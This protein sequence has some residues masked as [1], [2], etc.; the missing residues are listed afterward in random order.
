M[1]KVFI[2]AVVGLFLAPWVSRAATWGAGEEYLL[3]SQERI[4]ENLYQAAGNMVVR[5]EIT[6]DALLAGGN[7]LVDAP[8]G[9]DVFLAGGSINFLGDAG[10]DVRILGG[11]IT[12]DS[13]I[14]GDVLV[15]G[16]SVNILPSAVIAGDVFVA[17]G[18]VVLAGEING[19]VKI[20]AA[21]AIVSG[22]VAKN[23]D[24]KVGEK[25]TIG[26]KGIIK[27][28]LTYQ[29]P[30]GR[31]T[32]NGSVEGEIIADEFPLRHAAK[33][34]GWFAGIFSLVGLLILLVSGLLLILF[35]GRFSKEVAALGAENFG[36]ESF[37]GFAILIL[38]PALCL[39]L[40]ISILGAIFAVL[41]AALYIALLILAKISA[42][43]IFGVLLE[44]WIRRK[45]SVE[46]TIGNGL[47]GIAIL[48][49]L[50]FLPFLGWLISL[51]FFLVALGTLGRLLY[52]RLPL[53]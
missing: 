49:I 52:R 39:L 51:F 21:E 10:G 13:T 44:K 26:E 32:N 24:I 35:I 1:K 20:F 38:G 9:E 4:E 16:G 22:L 25:L 30:E 27:G 31:F 17:G 14:L 6:G 47:I 23:T 34:W 33:G 40:G 46:L 41:G 50:A 15:F 8:I 28:N 29:A 36:K 5:G 37:R 3:T 53:D 7:V 43:F 45:G 42:G 18:R 12:I 48:Y 11:N 19:R 2:I